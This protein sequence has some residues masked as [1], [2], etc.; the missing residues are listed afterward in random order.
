[1]TH[2]N[3]LALLINPDIVHGVDIILSS[4]INKNIAI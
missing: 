4:I 2:D 3:E 1:M